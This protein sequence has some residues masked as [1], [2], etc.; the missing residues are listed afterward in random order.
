MVLFTRPPACL[1]LNN[2][3]WSPCTL[4]PPTTTAI[5]LETHDAETSSHQGS[6]HRQRRRHQHALATPLHFTPCQRKHSIKW[7]LKQTQIF[8]PDT[9]GTTPDAHHNDGESRSSTIP[10][11]ID[12]YLLAT[13]LIL[14]AAL[15]DFE[16]NRTQ[17]HPLC[18]QHNNIDHDTDSPNN[19]SD[20]DLDNDPSPLHE[21]DSYFTETALILDD[22]LNNFRYT[23]DRHPSHNHP[24]RHD[25]AAIAPPH[26][27][28]DSTPSNPHADQVTAPQQ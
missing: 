24:D 25:T 10:E 26:Q 12:L 9:P 6:L 8:P 18:D 2:T 14:N 11:Q 21:V 22:A 28:N 4:R 3:P 16:H 7:L 1:V 13:A 23:T 15:C 27:Q 20:E 5:P 17:Q 19:H